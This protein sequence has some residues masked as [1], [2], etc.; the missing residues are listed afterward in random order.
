MVELKGLNKFATEYELTDKESGLAIVN[1]VNFAQTL[2]KIKTES[3]FNIPYDVK[4]RSGSK[5]N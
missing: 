3:S 1:V 5:G 4:L 2:L